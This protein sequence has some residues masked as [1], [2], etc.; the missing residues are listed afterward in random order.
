MLPESDPPPYQG[1]Q[2]VCDYSPHGRTDLMQLQ[3]EEA[4]PSFHCH[5]ESKNQLCEW[6]R[7]RP[8]DHHTV[9]LIQTK[10][11]F[12]G[13]CRHNAVK[14]AENHLNLPAIV[15]AICATLLFIAAVSLENSPFKCLFFTCH[16]KFVVL[17]YCNELSPSGISSLHVL[18]D[19]NTTQY[20]RRSY[21]WSADGR[22]KLITCSSDFT[23]CRGPVRSA[24]SLSPLCFRMCRRIAPSVRVME[25]SHPAT[26]ATIKYLAAR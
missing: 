24:V 26:H 12:Y 1:L 23:A 5:K 19:A 15:N 10:T 21:T 25:R 22:L 8:A 18:Q 16:N 9:T 14:T 3:G 11:C 4:S 13:L 7:G 2:L 17:K 20:T 6:D